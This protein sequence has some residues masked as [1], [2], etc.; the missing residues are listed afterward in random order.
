M[1]D[2]TRFVALQRFLSNQCCQAGTARP[3]RAAC[4][5]LEPQVLRT[6]ALHSSLSFYGF[7]HCRRHPKLEFEVHVLDIYRVLWLWGAFRLGDSAPRATLTR[8]LRGS[9]AVEGGGFGGLKET[10]G[11]P[12][13]DL[14]ETLGQP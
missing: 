4:R 14:K 5:L 2:P 13:G 3:T 1:F 8:I 7:R 11:Q 9:V 12:W 6:C 10:L